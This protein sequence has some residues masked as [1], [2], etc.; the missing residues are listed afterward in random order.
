MATYEFWYSET[1]TY[2]A[3]FTAENLEQAQD[4][5][6]RADSGDIDLDELPEFSKSLKEVDTYIDP[7]R[8]QN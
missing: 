7:V 1:L 6:D 8:E 3:R 5:L 2:K 4:L